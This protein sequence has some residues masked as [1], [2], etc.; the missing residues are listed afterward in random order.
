MFAH[1][2]RFLL[3]LELVGYAVIGVWLHM[4]FGWSVAA[5]LAAAVACA[6]G[7]RLAYVG[8]STAIGL[9]AGRGRAAEERVSPAAVP[10]LLLREWRAVLLNNF[11]FVPWE[12]WCL[13]PD[14]EPV[15]GDAVP[16]VLVHGYFANRGYFAALV[17]SL[18]SAGVGPV[19][20]PN[21]SSAFASIERFAEELHARIERIAQATRQPRVVLVCHSMGGLAARCYLCRHGAARVLKL[22]T[23]ASPHGGTLLARFA[24]GLNARQMHRDSAFLRELCAREAERQPA[25]GVT[26]IY[27]P[28]D[29]LVMPQQTSRLAWAR[30][31]ALP[32]HGHVGILLSRRLAQVVLEELAEARA[33]EASYRSASTS[34][35]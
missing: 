34:A 27:S 32:G 15:A 18:E 16:V 28:H 25:C 17:R 19:F 12:R 1:Y 14:A 22:I 7:G 33:P 13:R 3:F 31:I 10:R 9:A 21:F 2:F 4:A 20:A 24:S 11:C 23:I 35:A 30:N 8:V 29:N 26:S 5:I 6:L